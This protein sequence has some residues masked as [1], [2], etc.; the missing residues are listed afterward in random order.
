ME[1]VEN[2]RGWIGEMRHH[3]EGVNVPMV[4]VGGI[5]ALALLM[6]INADIAVSYQ[7]TKQ[8]F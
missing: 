3:N 7:V 8:I 2:L 6:R 1:T 4:I 5:L